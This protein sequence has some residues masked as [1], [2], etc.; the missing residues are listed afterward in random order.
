MNCPYCGQ[1]LLQGAHFCTRCGKQIE[2]SMS[3][4]QPVM[5]QPSAAQPITLKITRA[6]QWFLINPPIKV[7]IDDTWRCQVQNAESI[8]VSNLNPGTHRFRFTITCRTRDICVDLQRDG[9]MF[10][11]MNR[12][13]GEIETY[14]R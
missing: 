3:Q 6:D 11:E 9:E 5:A 12:I 8:I 4:M 13:T 7:L 2:G 1:Q 10:L 14:M